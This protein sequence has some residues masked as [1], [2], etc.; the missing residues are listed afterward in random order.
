[1]IHFAKIKTDDCNQTVKW[2]VIHF[3][4]TFIYDPKI[5]ENGTFI[6]FKT[7]PFFTFIYDS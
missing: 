2:W 6:M 4:R 1:M 3:T 7:Q 5:Y